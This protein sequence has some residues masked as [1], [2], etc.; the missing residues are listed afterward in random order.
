MVEVVLQLIP[1]DAVIHIS[2]A[3]AKVLAYYGGADTEALR[4]KIL[5][6]PEAQI[7]AAK[8]DA[9]SELALML[10]TLLSE[11]RLVYHVV[12]IPEGGGAAETITIVKNGPIA[13][14]LT[15][16][17]SVDDQLKTRILPMD[18]DESGDQTDAIIKS[19]LSKTQVRPDLR[20]DRPAIMA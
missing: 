15:T 17:D 16:A 6:I 19:I 18:T 4:G 1:A 5:Y 12:V 14:L 2:G 9:E 3:S 13:A 10:R 20:V 7:L 8:G 11:G